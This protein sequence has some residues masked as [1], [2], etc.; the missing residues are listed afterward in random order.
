MTLLPK[1]LEDWFLINVLVGQQYVI[2]Y[3]ENSKME[4]LIIL[5][6]RPLEYAY[7][8]ESSVEEGVGPL[9]I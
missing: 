3:P 4:A 7:N 1:K 6:A 5:D 9:K 2:R 8:E